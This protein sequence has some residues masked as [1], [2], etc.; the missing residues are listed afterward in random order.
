MGSP[1]PPV[2]AP[3]TEPLYLWD[4]NGGFSEADGE[5]MGCNWNSASVADLD[6]YGDRNHGCASD[7][8][9]GIPTSTPYDNHKGDDD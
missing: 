7:E 3:E 5:C 4:G 2:H 6:G 9:I 1:T 8:R